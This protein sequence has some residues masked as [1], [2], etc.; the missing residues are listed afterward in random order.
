MLDLIKRYF[1]LLGGVVGVACAVF[2]ATAAGHIVEAAYLGDAA[3]GPTIAPVIGRGASPTAAARSKDGAAFAARNMFCADCTPP[4]PTDPIVEGPG[5]GVPTTALPIALLATSVSLRDADSY[6]T[7][8]NTE[9]QKQGAYAIGDLVPGATGAI[10][11]IHFKYVD[12]ENNHRLERVALIGAAP[13]P[14]PITAAPPPPAMPGDEP[15]I[16]TGI[17]KLDDTHYEVDKAVIAKVM[18]NP[19]AFARGARIVPAMKEGKPEGFRLSAIRPGSELARL[20]LV[21]GDTL[22]SIN[23]FEL[24]SV[25]KA[26]EVY[27]KLREA[28]SLEI[29]VTRRGKPVS[30]NYAIK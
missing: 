23:G 13:P 20:G 21:N 12:F 18:L 26:L 29:D 1:W 6:A 25:D 16:E 8:V 22:Q 5:G 28:T 14:P 17:K 7:I 3:H 19:V 15:V 4:L 11:E 30:L 2:L 9:N 24:T 10:K 27:T